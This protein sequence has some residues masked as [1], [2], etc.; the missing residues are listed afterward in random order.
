MLRSIQRVVLLDDGLMHLSTVHFSAMDQGPIAPARTRGANSVHEAL[1]AIQH[2]IFA[3]A[4][5][6]G[7]AI[8]SSERRV[9]VNEQ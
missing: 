3:S 6:I 8:T 9:R 1:S 5:A 2:A 7:R 4:L